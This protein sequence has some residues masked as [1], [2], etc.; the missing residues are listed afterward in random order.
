MRFNC[1]AGLLQ[2]CRI[3]EESLNHS[4]PPRREMDK[5]LMLGPVYDSNTGTIV[6]HKRTVTPVNYSFDRASKRF[7]FRQRYCKQNEHSQIRCMCHHSIDCTVCETIKISVD[8]A[9]GWSIMRQRFYMA[10]PPSHTTPSFWDRYDHKQHHL[11]EYPI[12]TK[13]IA[14]YTILKRRPLGP[15]TTPTVTAGV[16]G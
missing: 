16:A 15:K 2:P 9:I 5:D 4:V 8:A 14:L 3:S 11:K 7:S 6:Y 1:F 12:R 10:H 13:P